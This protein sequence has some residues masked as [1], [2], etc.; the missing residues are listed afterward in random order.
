M[1][2]MWKEKDRQRS[3]RSIVHRSAH[4]GRYTH[5]LQKFATSEKKLNPKE[6]DSF[7]TCHSPER[8][9]Q[10]DSSAV[11]HWLHGRRFPRPRSPSP[12]VSP[13]LR[14]HSSAKSSHG[15]SSEKP[16]DGQIPFESRSHLHSWL[17]KQRLKIHV[18]R[19]ASGTRWPRR[20]PRA[21][22]SR[23][24]RSL[25]PAWT[26]SQQQPSLATSS[27]LLLACLPLS[28][29]DENWVPPNKRK[30]KTQATPKIARN[31]KIF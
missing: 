2:E 19:P 18:S 11:E 1:K 22:T 7:A 10:L 4:R 23:R 26:P 14:P 17:K 20:H 30:Q 15:R 6:N 16:A 25:F 13:L 24:S 28:D 5:W 9:S 21:Q 8:F 27:S 12:S 3:Q 29:G 31:R